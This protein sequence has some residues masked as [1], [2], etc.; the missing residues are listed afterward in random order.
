MPVEYADDL[1][2]RLTCGRGGRH[3]A[4]A[5]ADAHP[6][7]E[8]PADDET[9]RLGGQRAETALNHI[10]HDV[11]HLLLARRVDPDAGDRIVAA[12]PAQDDLADQRRG[13]RDPVHR[14]QRVE[15]RRG[16]RN[17]SHGIARQYAPD[18]DR[19]VGMQR[20]H[21][22]RRRLAKLVGND[23]VRIGV[24][25][26]RQEVTV[27]AIHQR[28]DAD[29]DRNAQR[30]AADRDRSLA[31]AGH[32]MREGDGERQRRHG[33]ART[34]SPSRSRSG[35]SRTMA[36]ASTRPAR[37]SV[38]AGPTAPVSTSTRRARPWPTTTTN[39]AP[40]LPPVDGPCPTA[41]AGTR[42]ALSRSRGH[43]VDVDSHADHELGV[44]GQVG[45]DPERARARVALA[46]DVG[47]PGLEDL[48][49]EPVRVRSMGA[50]MRTPAISRSSTSAAMRLRA[51]EFDLEQDSVGGHGL[52]RLDIALHHDAVERRGDRVVFEL[53]GIKVDRG[54]RLVALLLSALER[55]RGE[56]AA[57]RQDARADDVGLGHPEPRPRVVEPG[58]R[59]AL[60]HPGEEVAL[61]HLV[62]LV[63]ENVGHAP[64]HRRAEAGV[65]DRLDDAGRID[66]LDRGAPRGMGHRY[67]RRAPKSHAPHADRRRRSRKDRRDCQNS[68]AQA[69]PAAQRR[70]LQG[71]RQRT[72]GGFNQ[73]GA[74][75]RGCA[76][77]SFHLPLLQNWKH[78]T[79]RVKTTA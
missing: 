1:E 30:D 68:P 32:Q 55:L 21:G 19:P 62:A 38:F 7:G 56:D 52:A 66:G 12:R 2:A 25:E 9:V 71:H 61:P 28:A 74:Q 58:E 8:L 17:A 43:N 50:P 34:L 73:I 45:L 26:L 23:D 69:S 67:G 36:S 5:E 59:L 14:V 18:L 79:V 4:V 70:R 48:V 37:I 54:C 57:V 41:L 33:A 16:A 35:F 40:G 22:L 24:D 46:A 53:S 15:D 65:V 77:L 13:R 76:R 10:V 60:V 64:G 44:C 63:D 3:D 27:E 75:R 20:S 29:E 51:V 6:V 11:G 72:A 47:D 78:S 49:R 31:L 39:G 42:R